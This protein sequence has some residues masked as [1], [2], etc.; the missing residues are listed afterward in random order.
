M[1]IWLKNLVEEFKN[2][3]LFPKK[4][5]DILTETEKKSSVKNRPVKVLTA[6]QITEI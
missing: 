4:E 2:T 3:I 6:L 5:L 1:H